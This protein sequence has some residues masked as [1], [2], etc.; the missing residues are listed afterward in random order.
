MKCHLCQKDSDLKNSHIIPEFVYNLLYDKK[1]RF[2]V[3]TTAD[4]PPRPQEQKGIRE[5]LLCVDCEN[6]LSVYEKHQTSSIGRFQRKSLLRRR[7]R[8]FLTHRLPKIQVIP[9]VY[10]VEGFRC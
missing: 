9:V 3:L 6:Q 7:L 2:H 5:H 10:I 4:N 1:H 8:L